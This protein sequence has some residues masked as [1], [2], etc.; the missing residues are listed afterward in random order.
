[1]GTI[2]QQKQDKLLKSYVG[3]AA[4]TSATLVITLSNSIKLSRA[5]TV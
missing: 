4:H 2:E 1:M 3:V 5:K